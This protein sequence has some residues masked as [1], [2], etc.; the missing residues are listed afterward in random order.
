[1]KDFGKEN[2]DAANVGWD[3]SHP[4][5]QKRNRESRKSL[6]ATGAGPNGVDLVS[7]MALATGN[8]S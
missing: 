3:K 6:L 1:M 7:G 4:A 5:M 8:C 2:V